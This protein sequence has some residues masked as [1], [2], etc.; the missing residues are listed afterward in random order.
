MIESNLPLLIP[1]VF[2]L[3]AILTPVF[4]I[5]HGRLSYLTALAA[6]GFAFVASL[7]GLERVLTHGKWSYHLGG[8][9]PPIG[10]EYV[11]DPLSGFF[12]VVVTGVALSVMFY[13]KHPTEVDVPKK[14]GYYYS[15]CMLFLCGLTGMVITGDMFNLYVFLEIAS[16]AGYALVAVGEKRSTVAAFRYLLLGT[17]GATFYLLGLGFLFVMTGSLNMADIA[18]IL[19]HMNESPT[20]IAGLCLMIIGI[21]VKMA[22]FPLHGWLPDAYTYASSS[23]T[24]LLAPIGTKVA[25]YVLIRVLYFVFES[26]FVAGTLPISNVILWTSIAGII[27]GSVMAIAQKELKRMLAYSSVAQVGYI[28]LGI[29]LANPLG[30]IGAALHVLNHACMKACLF[31]VAG[32]L[33][34][35]VGH[36]IISE[37]DDTLRQKMPWTMAAFAFGAISM[38]GLPPMGGFFSKWYLVMA[39]VDQSAWFS[40]AVILLSSLLTAVYFFRVLERVY[41]RSTVPTVALEHN[42]ASP[43]RTASPPRMNEAKFSM[44]VP[45]VS[46]AVVLLILGVFNS[47]IVSRVLTYTL[48]SGW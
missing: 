2:L 24:A 46:L 38:V 40:V 16:L 28:G 6:T 41:L 13:A 14:E 9:A 33:R 34:A 17:I 48:P 32:N 7:I 44:L 1:L 43:G 47:F 35:S 31:M 45:M 42:P 26:D 23:S 10:I 37:F 5:I 27:F 39:A 20:V 25:V 12:A 4:G 3:A 30:L 15:V 11:L 8:W 21:G 18:K 22:L 29:G 36:S 19:P